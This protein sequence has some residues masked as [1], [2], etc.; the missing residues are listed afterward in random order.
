MKKKHL[1]L[2]GVG[3][4]YVVI[5]ML[6]TAAGICISELGLINSGKFT[7]LSIPLAVVGMLLIAYGLMLWI[8][9]N[10]HSR[11]GENIEKNNLI[12][13]GVYAYV[14]NP[15]YSAFLMLCTGLLLFE[16][17]LWLLILPVIYWIYLTILMKYTE[18]KWLTKLYGNEYV[19][20]CERVNRCI[21]F[22]PRK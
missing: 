19:E 20:Y 17:N 12:T 5:I 14:R 3:P 15:V 18:E 16:D 9:A 1:P 11:L 4:I 7:F 6:M 2:I 8:F 13:T 21:P 22:I 10:F